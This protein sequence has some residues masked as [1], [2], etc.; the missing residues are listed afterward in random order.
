MHWEGKDIRCPREGRGRVVLFAVGRELGCNGRGWGWVGKI[1][2][3]KIFLGKRGRAA[4]PPE[5]RVVD[6]PAR[7]RGAIFPGRKRRG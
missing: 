7:G 4:F 6:V 1:H 3:Y 5:E 2:M